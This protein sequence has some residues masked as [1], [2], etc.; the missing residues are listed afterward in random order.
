M[1]LPVNKPGYKLY[2]DM[3]AEKF[4]I[5][6]GRFGD[7]NYILGDSDSLPDISLPSAP[8]FAIGSIYL[9]IPYEIDILIHE[10]D[11]NQIEIEFGED[12]NDN[13]ALQTLSDS[14]PHDIILKVNTYSQWVPGM[15]SPFNESEV[16]LIGI[17]PDKF[18]LAICSGEKKIWLHEVYSGVNHLIPVSN[19]YNS[20]MLFRNERK[21]EKVLNP[22]LFFDNLGSFNDNELASAFILYNQYMR[23]RLL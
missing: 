5:G 12:I 22:N 20:L 17:K 7:G 4:V 6:E 9:H 15:K 14:L 19:Y 16:R 21:M 3:I 8:V 2:R 18:I 11:D 23:R 1:I 10:E 13:P